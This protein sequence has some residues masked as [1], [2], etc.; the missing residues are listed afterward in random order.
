MDSSIKDILAFSPNDSRYAD[1]LLKPSEGYFSPRSYGTDNIPKDRPVLFVG[2]HTIYGVFDPMLI[3]KSIYQHSGI[4]PR[5]LADH[6][7]FGVPLWTRFIK[8][9]GIV[10]GTR[11]I[12]SAL[13]KDQ[14]SV[15]V[16]PGGAREVFKR[17]GECYKLVWKKRVGFLKMAID[18]G[19][20]IVPFASVGPD[21]ALSIVV[22]ANGIAK[23]LGRRFRESRF[24]NK[25]LRN[26]DMIPPIT[27]GI[28][29][30]SIPRPERFYF[31]F[32]EPIKTSELQ[33]REQTEALLFETREVVAEAIN[34]QIA[35][36][37]DIR[38]QDNDKGW[39]RKL[40]TAL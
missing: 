33:G 14:Q 35:E 18:H 22:D 6:M 17:K 36:L 38:A 9:M 24:Y 8:S 19:Y 7:H 5:S 11:E 25:T 26:G 39:V 20:D 16:F 21:D 30:T 23:G 12:C 34:S 13:M 37:I 1:K 3:V 4:F 29:L 15:L 28:G 10:E 31:S 40:L 27:R 2:N 32:G